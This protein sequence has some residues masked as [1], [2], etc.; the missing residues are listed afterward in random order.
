MQQGT[1]FC[2]GVGGMK[3]GCRLVTRGRGADG[4][5]PMGV[6]PAVDA[7]FQ[8]VPVGGLRAQ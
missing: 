8:C 1:G 4:W 2:D 7:G 6:Q 5:P 3:R